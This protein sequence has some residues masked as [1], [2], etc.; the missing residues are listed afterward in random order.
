MIVP[1]LFSTDTDDA[2][3]SQSFIHS[4]NFIRKR[5]FLVFEIHCIVLLVARV[6]AG[7][8]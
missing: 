2:L 8:D 1:V 4:E 5:L 3:V 6:E 7:F